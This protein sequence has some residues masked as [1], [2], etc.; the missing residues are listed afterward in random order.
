MFK[1]KKIDKGKKV[2]N[3]VKRNESENESKI[4][5]KSR[6]IV[7]YFECSGY[8]H[9]RSECPNL[10]KNKGKALNVILNDESDFE[11]SNPSSDNECVFVTFSDTINGSTDMK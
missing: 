10:K 2:N 9:L 11:N 3:F 8:G 4:K 6:K 7:K 1:K 5:T